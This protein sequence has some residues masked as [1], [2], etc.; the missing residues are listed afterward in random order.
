MELRYGKQLTLTG[1]LRQPQAQRNPG[2]FDYRG[3]LARQKVH[4]IIDSRGLVRIGKQV[5]FPPLGWI[6]RFRLRVETAIKATYR[7]KPLHAQLIKGILLGKRSDIPSE[8]LD[9]FR[10][11]GTFHVLAVSGLHV[12]LIAAFCYLGFSRL[13]LPKEVLCVLTIVAVL[14]YACIVGFR[15]SVFRASLMAILFLFARIINRDADIFNLLAV[16]A[17]LLLLLNPTQVWDVGFQLSFVAVAAIVYLVPKMEKHLRDWWQPLEFY[18]D[19][20]SGIQRLFIR[21]GRR[22]LKWLVLSYVITLAAQLG[23]GPIIA[24]HFFRVYPWGILVGPF[25][26]GFVSLIV[27][28]GLLSIGAG[29]IWLPLAKPLALLNDAII[30]LFLELIAIFGEVGGVLKVKPPTLGFFCLYG[31]LCL[32]IVHWRF[33]Y[34]QWRLATLVGLC[35]IAVWVWDR[36]FREKGQLLEV[37][38][39]DVGQGDA[40][41]I[42]FPDKR[43]MLIDGGIRRAYYDEKRQRHIEYDAGERI[44]A[45]YLDSRGIRQLDIVL[46]THPDIDHGG[47]LVHIL[48]NFDVRQ[49]IGI[50]DG[51]SGSSTLARL[52]NTAKE[53]GIPYSFKYAGDIQLTP[54]ATLTLLHPIDAS[55]TELM[56][57]DTNNDSLVIKLSYG[58][59]DML[60]TGDIGAPAESA[61]IASG[62]DLRAE[63]LKV[64]HHGSR[65]SS[66]ARFLDAVQARYAI[67][68][69]GK[70]NRYRFPHPDVV[71][72][73]QE[74]GCVQLRT[75]ELGAI[76]LKTDG[77]RCWFRYH[78]FDEGAPSDSSDLTIKGK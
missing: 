55:T 73:Y 60:F 58:T 33:V 6:E 21:L 20:S 29:L 16:A 9:V 48:E 11:S 56:D 64:P 44:V 26:V 68:S 31:G 32:G 5:G 24:F 45:P 13:P 72:R 47:G 52:R 38:T 28:V 62:Q 74:R 41:V 27:A 66:T 50:S 49:V 12:G 40:A 78:V 61:L 23:T 43:T 4:G 67:F 37:V 2:G 65:T 14:V 69:L 1:V 7:T 77:T 70:R 39:L 71:T 42:I 3:Y 51:I 19:D 75:D 63:I 15:P 35:L 54:T 30:F 10:N 17:L 57:K 25:A 53:R 46:L 76:T 59:V 8:T 34:N 36:A 18:R 22:A